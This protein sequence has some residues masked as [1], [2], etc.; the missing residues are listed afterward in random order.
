MGRACLQVWRGPGPHPGSEPCLTQLEWGMEGVGWQ[1][2]GRFKGP[3]AP[4][5]LGSGYRSPFLCQLKDGMGMLEGG[6]G[7]LSLRWRR[8]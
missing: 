8:N 7:P 4:S 6:K 1:S 5:L 2:Q 3:Q